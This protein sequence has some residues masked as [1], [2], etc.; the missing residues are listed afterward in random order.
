VAADFLRLFGDE[1][2]EVPLLLGVAVGADAD[3]TQAHTVAH[4]D[5]MVLDDQAMPAR[6]G[7]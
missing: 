2:A 6:P 5:A 3:N 7:H 4:V 1:S